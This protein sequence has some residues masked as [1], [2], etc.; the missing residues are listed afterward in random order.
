MLTLTQHGDNTY[1]IRHNDQAALRLQETD[2]G[3]TITGLAPGDMPDVQSDDQSGDKDEDSGHPFRRL[4]PHYVVS[5]VDDDDEDDDNGTSDAVITV[6]RQPQ[7]TVEHYN[8]TGNTII[9]AL[10]D[11]V[12]DTPLV[13]ISADGTLTNVLD[14]ARH[15]V[16]DPHDL[17]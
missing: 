10:T 1:V 5:V 2:T 13:E 8:S 6:D 3:I 4:N 14:L 9:W 15:G 17:H 16:I 7:L 11:R 12:A